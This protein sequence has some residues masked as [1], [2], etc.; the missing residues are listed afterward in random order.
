MKT[1]ISLWHDAYGMGRVRASDIVELLDPK[2]SSFLK[3]YLYELA[4]HAAATQIGKIL[5]GLSESNISFDIHTLWGTECVSVQRILNGSK[6]GYRLS[7]LS[8]DAIEYEPFRDSHVCFAGGEI[9]LQLGAERINVLLSGEVEPE[10][11]GNIA[12]AHYM[13]MNPN[14]TERHWI[15]RTELDTFCKKHGLTP[16]LMSMVARGV[17]RHHL[18]WT[19]YRID[20]PDVIDNFYQESI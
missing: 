3:R 2:S 12:R 20:K 9:H 19:G 5:D 8:G 6:P 4:P 13:F 1:L 16:S 11:I 10:E 7:S 15:E 14:G 17:R 18:S